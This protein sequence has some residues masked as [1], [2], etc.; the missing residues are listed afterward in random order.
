MNSNKVN[1][2]MKESKPKKGKKELM[3][4][5]VREWCEDTTS[6][7]F[8]NMV[9]TD[10]WVIRIIW[11]ILIIASMGYCIYSNSIWLIFP[12]IILKILLWVSNF[13]K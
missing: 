13:F 9:K 7:G 5:C 2:G 1:H 12:F 10:S 3:K 6:H 4:E 11:V 8:K